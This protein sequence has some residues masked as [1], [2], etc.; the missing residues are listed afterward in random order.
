MKKLFVVCV[1]VVFLVLASVSSVG[2]VTTTPTPTDS[3]SPTAA[4]TAAVSKDIQDLKDKLATKVAELRKTNQKA[5]SGVVEAVEAKT[6]TIK[7]KNDKSV[8]VKLDDVLTHTFEING[9]TKKEIKT[10]GLE[11][12]DYII[13]SGPASDS[14]VTAN[15]I[16]KDEQYLVG[17]GKITKVNSGDFSLG[18]ATEDK[19][20]LT[21][22]I[23]NTTKRLLLDSKTLD[24][25]VIG[26]TKIKEG[27][28]VHFVLKKTGQEKVK[29]RYSALRI[30]IIPQEYFVAK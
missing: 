23:E 13:I 15:T 22:D 3:D 12:G 24:K 9:T 21:L 8:T 17:S 16:Y 19:E 18:V 1:A 25:E 7:D 2:A 5:V 14:T 29:D 27:D 6:I 30:V 28:T 26:F 10:S 11:K 4:P 20:N